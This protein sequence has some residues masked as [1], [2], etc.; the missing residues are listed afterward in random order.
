MNGFDIEHNLEALEK[1]ITARFKE[2]EME[3]IK[4]LSSPGYSE[5][6]AGF[7][8]GENL[9][10]I[11][12]SFKEGIVTENQNVFQTLAYGG[13]FLKRIPGEEDEYINVPPS[14]TLQKYIGKR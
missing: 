14:A 8:V 11:E 3:V 12:I 9:S 2:G 6:I 7:N 13:A 1:T 4:V 5:I 10:E